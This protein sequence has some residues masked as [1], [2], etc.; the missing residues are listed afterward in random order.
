MGEEFLLETAIRNLLGNALEFIPK[1]DGKIEL[2]IEER[3][4]F[5]R[6]EIRDNGPGLPD[7][8]LGKVFNHFY[9]LPRPH[10][11]HKSSGLGLCFVRECAQ[12]HGGQADLTNHID[13]GA[14]ATLELQAADEL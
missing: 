14:L 11:G 6:L 4:K 1:E 5:I 10:S 8:A 7:Y 2:T 9:S 12:L 3:G 13:G